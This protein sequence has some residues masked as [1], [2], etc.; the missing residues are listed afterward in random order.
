MPEVSIG[1][2]KLDLV[3]RTASSGGVKVTILEYEDRTFKVEYSGSMPEQASHGL[4]A[5]V[6]DAF[7]RAG[8]HIVDEHRPAP[9]SSLPGSGVKRKVHSLMPNGSSLSVCGRSANLLRFTDRPEDIT[10]EVCRA[11]R[12]RLSA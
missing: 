7:E 5:E 11:K 3:A 12:S 2:W 1:P 10:C 4:A 6:F 9:S 8:V